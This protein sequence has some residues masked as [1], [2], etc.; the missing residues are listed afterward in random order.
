MRIK[1]SWQTLI[2]L[3]ASLITASCYATLA[4]SANA[5]SSEIKSEIDILTPHKSRIE[6]RLKA[7][8]P[9]IKHISSQLID[10]SLPKHL[11]LLPMLESSY[12]PK[13]VSP[14]N[15]AG[16][17][18]LIPATAQRFGLNI[19]ERDDQRFDSIASTKAAIG[20]LVFLYNKFDDLSLTL[21]A[22]NAGE[23]RVARAIKKA[24]T[25]E[26]S[27]LKLPKET[28]QYVR[29]FYALLHLIK[30]DTLLDDGP[31]PMLLFGT[32]DLPP[33]IDLRPLPPLIRL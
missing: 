33:L 29:R 10:R 11:V 14:A 23:G 2:L 18:Q 27:S 7:N 17:W 5:L 24:G 12:N 3:T 1:Y 22:Y 20:Y 15:A 13:A 6:L 19:D 4:R 16:L 8:K 28:K 30:L 31:P 32:S 25:R 26:F 21:A 9:L